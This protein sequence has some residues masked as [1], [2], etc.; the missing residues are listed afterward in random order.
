MESERFTILAQLGCGATGQVYKA[1]DN[2]C[3]TICAVKRVRRDLPPRIEERTRTITKLAQQVES[4]FVA[5]IYDFVEEG[6]YF[7][8]QMEYCERGNLLDLLQQEIRIPEA[9]AAI[10]FYEIII[11]LRDI[12]E[13]RIL[14][15]DVKVDNILLDKHG[16]ARLS[17]FGF[18]TV[19]ENDDPQKRTAC[20]TPAYAA[21][22]MILREA[23][24]TKTDIWSAGVVLY[25]L[26]TGKLPFDGPNIHECMRQVVECEPKYPEYVSAQCKDLLSHVLDKNPDSR[27]GVHEILMHPWITNGMKGTSFSQTGIEEI[28]RIARSPETELKV[29]ERMGLD[30]DIWR[31]HRDLGNN[32]QLVKH[33]R[34]LRD[35]IMLVVMF[36]KLGTYMNGYRGIMKCTALLGMV[37]Q[38]RKMAASMFTIPGGGGG[39]NRSK[40]MKSGFY[41]KSCA[42]PTSSPWTLKCRKVTTKPAT[43]L[44]PPEPF[45]L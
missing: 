30:V 8:I 10:L 36:Q 21:P 28:E 17:D 42:T 4:P 24:T 27:Y 29:C 12:H 38:A 14:H 37:P 26:V 18:S 7:Y 39:I 44:D 6:D 23:Y 13:A 34:M 35:S 33:W 40:S 1:I 45:D 19:F 11:A 22:E 43:L 32:P 31:M 15:R 41:R 2:V 16:H 9:K 20:G 25:V 5:H 3:R